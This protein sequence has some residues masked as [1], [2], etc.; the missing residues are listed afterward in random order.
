MYY[1]AIFLVNMMAAVKKSPQSGL[2]PQALTVAGDAG[3]SLSWRLQSM[4]TNAS[5]HHLLS[6][7]HLILFNV[8]HDG[9]LY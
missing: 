9:S 2:S 5:C 7:L 1:G 3:G 6:S 8:K 4:R